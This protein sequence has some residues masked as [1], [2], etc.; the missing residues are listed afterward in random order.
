MAQKMSK[1][2]PLEGY[3]YADGSAKTHIEKMMDQI[4]KIS[5]NNEMNSE[6]KAEKI[7]ALYE[8]VVEVAFEH[9]IC[10]DRVIDYIDWLYDRDEDAAAF[11]L[12]LKLFNTLKDMVNPNRHALE[13]ICNRLEE[14]AYEIGD[15]DELMDEILY[16]RVRNDV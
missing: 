6:E 11:D 13:M 14:I 16:T 2:Y 9:E 4:I 5:K 7:R 12:A 8:N 15:C 1:W 10:F 3:N